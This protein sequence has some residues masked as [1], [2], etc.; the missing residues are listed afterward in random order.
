MSTNELKFLL[1]DDHL[2]V[3][4][5]MQFV[6]EDLYEDTIF[7][8]VS[9]MKQLVDILQQNMVDILILDA[10]FPDGV[11][12]SII[13]E[14]KRIQPQIKILIFTSFEE[15]NFS[16]KFIEAGV[17]GFLSK[18]SEEDEIRNAIQSMVEKGH[19]FSP[20]TQKLIELSKYNPLLTNPLLQLSE[21]ELE[22][23]KMYAKGYGNLEIANEL[24]LKQNTVSTFKKRIFEKL[25]INSL[26]E[27]ADLVKIHSDSSM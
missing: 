13:P 1:A 18:L 27:L 9:N 4:Q 26:I 11:S 7:S 22:I 19:Y 20:L 6:I 24:S 2:I 23:A 3:R 14:I 15:E 12:L 25:N 8:H 10:Q 17:N 16:L 5:G 21:R